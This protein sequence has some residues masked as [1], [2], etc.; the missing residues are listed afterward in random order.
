MITRYYSIYDT[1]ENEKR[2]KRVKEN[3][4][5]TTA[6]KRGVDEA[7]VFAAGE[8]LGMTR[9]QCEAWL[10]YQRKVTDWSFWNGNSVTI[11]NFRRSL[12]MWKIIDDQKSEERLE[13]WQA[14]QAREEIYR[15]K[16]EEAS[17]LLKSI[18]TNRA[19]LR[20]REEDRERVQKEGEARQKA[21]EEKRLK[22]ALAAPE[23]WLLCSEECEHYDSEKRCC[24]AGCHIPPQLRSWPIPPRECHAFARLASLDAV[25]S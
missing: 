14:T 21:A 11:R 6:R 16:K 3:T 19:A 5:T 10:K 25:R 15:H 18:E 4:T 13:R 20:K 24:S 12:R 8:L 17:N 22:E 23:A 2:S 1:K 7:E 9:E